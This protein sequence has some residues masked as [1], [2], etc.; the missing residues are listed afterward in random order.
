M[1]F[2]LTVALGALV[3][4]WAFL[5]LAVQYRIERRLMILS[6]LVQGLLVGQ[7][8]LLQGLRITP[9]K[10]PIQAVHKSPLVARNGGRLS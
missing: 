2:W 6:T 8:L 9:D 1:E 10:G 5:M 4:A 3:A 7:D